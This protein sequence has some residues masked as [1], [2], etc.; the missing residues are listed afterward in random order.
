MKNRRI[1]V[2]T[3]QINEKLFSFW[4]NHIQRRLKEMDEPVEY[5]IQKYVVKRNRAFKNIISTDEILGGFE[6]IV[7]ADFIFYINDWGQ[8]QRIKDRWYAI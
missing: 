4:I 2:L 7:L 3:N 8:V 5:I 1:Q 6:P